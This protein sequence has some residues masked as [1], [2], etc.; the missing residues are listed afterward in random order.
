MNSN[1]A[2][3]LFLY[4]SYD[5]T[6]SFHREIKDVSVLMQKRA[7][8]N[9]FKP[10]NPPIDPNDK[11]LGSH[12]KLAFSWLENC[13]T[14]MGDLAFR[15]QFTR[16]ITLPGTCTAFLTKYKGMF[17]ILNIYF[18]LFFIAKEFSRTKRPFILCRYTNCH[19]T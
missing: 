3:V 12:I 15:N 1:F 7:K 6:S 11:Y 17:Y 4:R 16:P 9:C 19:W 5:K 10:E 2:V 13:K 8:A 18:K 14:L